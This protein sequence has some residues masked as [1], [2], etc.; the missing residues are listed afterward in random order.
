LV[1]TLLSP[2][3]SVPSP[4]AS[5]DFGEYLVE[6]IAPARSL[7]FLSPD[8]A[9][10]GAHQVAG[11]VFRKELAPGI[12]DQVLPLPTNRDLPAAALPRKKWVRLFS[13]DPGE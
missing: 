12:H 11:L 9:A 6:S 13:A 8:G 10:R 4:V 5:E 1:E 2:E 7:S 3:Q